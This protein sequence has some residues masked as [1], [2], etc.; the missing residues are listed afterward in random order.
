[1]VTERAASTDDPGHGAPIAGALSEARRLAPNF[2]FA[3][4]RPRLRRD[5]DGIL[6]FVLRTDEVDRDAVTYAAKLFA[7]LH[8]I[9]TLTLDGA[10]VAILRF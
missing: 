9:D 7:I 4:Y 10:R 2:A 1:V 3:R 6:E 8:R 5:V